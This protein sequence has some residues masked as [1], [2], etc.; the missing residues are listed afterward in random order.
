MDELEQ[1]LN[2]LTFES[3]NKQN[4]LIHSNKAARD[5]AAASLPLNSCGLCNY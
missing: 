3:A 5:E 2:L 4:N 1:S